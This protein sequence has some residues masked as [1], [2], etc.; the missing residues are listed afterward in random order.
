M[1]LKFKKGKDAKGDLLEGFDQ[2]G[3]AMQAYCM[4]LLGKQNAFRKEVDI[5][6]VCQ[7]PVLNMVQQLHMCR[8]FT[9]MDIK[10]AFF[11][12]PNFKS[13]GSDGFNSGFYKATWQK[14]GQ[15]CVLLSRNSF[16]KRACQF[17]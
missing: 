5:Q 1:S 17:I 7:G 10:E 11:S 15:W 13:P 4:D 14:I 12:I 8:D 3:K 9:D 6:V 2:V 16:I